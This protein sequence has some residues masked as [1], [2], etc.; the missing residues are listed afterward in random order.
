MRLSLAMANCCIPDA[1]CIDWIHDNNET[2][3]ASLE[4]LVAA[5]YTFVILRDPFARLA[6]CFL[7]KIVSKSLP[8]HRLRDLTK[9]PLDLDKMSFADFV[10]LLGDEA[11]LAGN[12]HWRPQT[13]F[14]VYDH[15]DD[16]FSVENLGGAAAAISDR[17]ALEI[18]DA[19]PLTAHG[20]DR[21]EL[22][23][24]NIDHSGTPVGEIAGLKL[25]G[26]CP[27]PR[28]LF[29]NP[30]IVRVAQIYASDMALYA[31][32]IGPS[33]FFGTV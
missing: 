11:V 5:R 29:T 27:D 17:A 24:I 10:E 26:C 23:P 22:L 15:Y 28:S 19:R 25:N 12:M 1:S 16:Y 2:F 7:D 32:T 6:S 3:Q 9:G 21:F 13:D 30:L 33:T 18:C 14:L 4:D 20:L 31:E 8:A